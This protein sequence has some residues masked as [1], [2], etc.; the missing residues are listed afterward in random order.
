MNE[1]S[2]LKRNR[3]MQALFYI[4]GCLFIAVSIFFIYG[5]FYNIMDIN[6]PL[7]MRI[8]GLLLSLGGSSFFIVFSILLLG[9]RFFKIFKDGFQIYHHIIF[10]R[11]EKNRIL[12]DEIESYSIKN[13]EIKLIF[14]N[15][16]SVLIEKID[17]DEL[18]VLRANLDLYIRPSP[19]GIPSTS[20]K[21]NT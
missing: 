14:H 6:R 5:I 12:F 2:F 19:A 13:N 8:E 17:K 3:I 10:H 4:G 7:N 20:N 1:P 9:V 15:G 18:K 11:K 21:A 16:Q